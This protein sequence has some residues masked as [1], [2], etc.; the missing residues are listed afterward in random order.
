VFRIYDKKKEDIDK[1]I[2][3]AGAKFLLTIPGA[4]FKYSEFQHRKPVIEGATCVKQF[5]FTKSG[6]RRFGNLTTDK[7]IADLKDYCHRIMMRILPPATPTSTLYFGVSLNG[8]IDDIKKQ[9]YEALDNYLDITNTRRHDRK[10]KYYLIA[11]DLI[12]AGK[13]YHSCGSLMGAAFHEIDLKDSDLK[14]SSTITHKRKK[15]KEPF[16]EARNIENYYKKGRSLI[17]AGYKK[18]LHLA[19]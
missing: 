11:Y 3:F 8:N 13:D 12:E 17:N 2:T 10:W 15:T 5:L 4:G 6:A 18:H 16:Y 9:I 1:Y 14:K 19:K 7:N